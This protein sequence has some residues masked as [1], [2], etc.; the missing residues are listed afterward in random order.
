MIHVWKNNS[1]Q[2]ENISNMCDKLLIF[3]SISGT[4]L[5]DSNRVCSQLCHDFWNLYGHCI[6]Y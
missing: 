3:S 5:A 4:Y 1:N 6:Q 2:N